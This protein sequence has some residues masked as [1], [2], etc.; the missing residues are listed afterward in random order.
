MEIRPMTQAEQ[1]YSYTQSQQLLSQCGCVGYLR[2]DFDSG[3]YGFYSTWNDHCTRYKTDEFKAELDT[4]INDLRFDE[5]YGGLLKDRNS[6]SQYCREHKEGSFNGNYCTEYG[7]RVDTENYAY[8]CRC[9]TNKGDYNFYIYP[10]VAK[11]LDAHI[12]N[13][14]LGIRFI[15]SRYKELFRIP[16]GGKIVVTTAWGE[17]MERSCRYIDETHTE[18][19]NDLYHICEFAERMEKNGASYE[20]KQAEPLDGKKP[21]KKDYER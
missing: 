13:A 18:I 14:E 19:G 3:G 1:K 5:Q 8:L 17:K 7:F 21:K 6:M 11:W 15:D 10:Y 12:Q 20:P 4:V 2:G 16:D 9:N